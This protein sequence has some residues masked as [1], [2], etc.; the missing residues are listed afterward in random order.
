MLSHLL[1][2]SPLVEHFLPPLLFSF[3]SYFPLI[4]PV[5]L[6]TDNQFSRSLFL[7]P[8]AIC[9]YP[10]VCLSLYT[11]YEGYTVNENY[12][13]YHWGWGFFQELGPERSHKKPRPH[14][15]GETRLEGLCL[16]EDN[17]QERKALAGNGLTC[18]STWNLFSGIGKQCLFQDFVHKGQIDPVQSIQLSWKPHIPRPKSWIFLCFTHYWYHHFLAHVIHM[19]TSSWWSRAQK[20]MCNTENQNPYFFSI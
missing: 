18:S 4:S 3:L 16:K 14:F 5:M 7:W 6:L 12:A 11:T 8:L 1:S 9:Y 20:F 15:N 2:L 19:Q 17:G 13:S 10:P